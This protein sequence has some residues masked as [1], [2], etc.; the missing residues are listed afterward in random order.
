MQA[1]MK[2]QRIPS[3]ISLKHRILLLRWIVKQRTAV[4]TAIVS[5][6]PSISESQ[7]AGLV[8]VRI[9][10][11]QAFS[12]PVDADRRNMLYVGKACLRK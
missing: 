5:A 12:V 6:M 3:A 2:G 1:F 8:P 10:S 9:Q 11:V 4:L 7:A